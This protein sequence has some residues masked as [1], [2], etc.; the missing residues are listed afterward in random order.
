MQLKHS[1]KQR[2]AYQREYIS[3]GSSLTEEGQLPNL[4]SPLAFQSHLSGEEKEKKHF[5]MSQL[6][7]S[8]PW[9]DWDLITR[10]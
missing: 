7:D 1:P 4:Q 9:K 3:P 2:P 6:K 8:D 10:L 5:W